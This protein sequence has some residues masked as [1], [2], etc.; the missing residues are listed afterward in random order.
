[1]NANERCTN[2]CCFQRCA[3]GV[4][5]CD[6]SADCPTDT[7]YYCITGCCIEVPN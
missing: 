1:M 7:A 6:T 4:T 3:D 2:G 5:P